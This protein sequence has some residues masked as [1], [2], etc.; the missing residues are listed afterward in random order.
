MQIPKRENLFLIFYS[1]VA[2]YKH[3]FI[4]DKGCLYIGTEG[5]LTTLQKIIVRKIMEYVSLDCVENQPIRLWNYTCVKCHKGDV[6]IHQDEHHAP[7][8]ER[9]SCNDNKITQ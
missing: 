8:K 7:N 3:S 5:V 4:R 6:D 9:F 2:I 1:S